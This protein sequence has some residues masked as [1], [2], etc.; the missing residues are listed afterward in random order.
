MAAGATGS[1]GA[2]PEHEGGVLFSASAKDLW[3][4]GYGALMWRPG[5]GHQCSLSER[6][7][8]RVRSRAQPG[9]RTAGG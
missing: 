1:T 8:R 6:A 3:V 7:T 4:F 2:A 5:P 9:A